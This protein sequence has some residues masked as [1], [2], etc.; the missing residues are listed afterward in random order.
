MLPC[1][2]L[3][4]LCALRGE[5]GLPSIRPSLTQFDPVCHGSCRA[6]D[7]GAKVFPKLPCL[8]LVSCPFTILYRARRKGSSNI[9]IQF[10]HRGG[11]VTDE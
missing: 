6:T 9:G 1:S 5:V 10:L 8:T 7:D 11:G 2:W 3:E 4:A